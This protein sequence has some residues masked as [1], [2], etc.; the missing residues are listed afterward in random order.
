MWG[1]G[2]CRALWP[3]GRR[4]TPRNGNYLSMFPRGL[5]QR[6]NVRWGWWLLHAV[7]PGRIPASVNIFYKGALRRIQSA[8]RQEGRSGDRLQEISSLQLAVSC[9]LIVLASTHR[10]TSSAGMSSSCMRKL[11]RK[12]SL[13]LSNSAQGPKKETLPSCRK[14]S[15]SA[16]RF[17]KCV[18]CVTTM[19]VL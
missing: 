8:S 1:G 15:T 19:D 16:R 7:V 14:T 6:L 13:E 10:V 18:S 5:D 9:L 4:A 2:A 3:T 11:W 12:G 17:A